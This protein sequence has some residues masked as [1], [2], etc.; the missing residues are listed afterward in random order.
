MR[1]SSPI[2]AAFGPGLDKNYE[3]EVAMRK[4]IFS[5]MLSIDGF[6]EGPGEDGEKIDWM[7][8]DDEWDAYAVELLSEADTLLLGRTTYEGFVDF[9]P[10]QA[11]ELAE[12]LNATAKAVFSKTLTE[13]DWSNSRLVREGT[14]EEAASLKAEPGKNIVVLGSPTLAAE[15]SRYDLI[16]EYRFAVNPVLLSEGTRMFKDRVDRLTLRLLETRTFASGI[17]ELRYT[18]ERQP[19]AP[20]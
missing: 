1:E 19:G 20:A 18:P 7:C 2:G 8:A 10:S 11:G 15:L 6:F 14:L 3:H 9:W 17:I 13:T 12:L 4:V 16:D 5:I